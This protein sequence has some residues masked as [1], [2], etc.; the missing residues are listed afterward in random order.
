MVNVIDAAQLEYQ[1]QWSQETFGPHIRE[2]A[3][4]A[5]IREELEEVLEDPEDLTEWVD[6]IL[7][8]FDGAM[9]TGWEPQEVIDGIFA[10]QAVNETRVWPDWRDFDPSEAI[11]HIE[12]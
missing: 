4:V 9:R 5:H 10:K 1:R 6:V 11:G 8:A 3:I 7:L 2:E 12:V